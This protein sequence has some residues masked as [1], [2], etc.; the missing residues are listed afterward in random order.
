[1]KQLAGFLLIS[2]LMAHL[3]TVLVRFPQHFLDST[4]AEH[5]KAHLASQI[6]LSSGLC[7]TML[8]LIWR[9]YNSGPRWLWWSLLAYGFFTFAGYWG[10]KFAFEIE[11]PWRNGNS[12]FLVLTL[13]YVTGLVLSWRHC[14]I[15]CPRS[16][17]GGLAS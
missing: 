13:T 16:Q 17:S 14:F 5:A 6:S 8:I 11:G 12:L 4:W 3:F 2:T 10:G 7:L 1:M 15:E 9:F